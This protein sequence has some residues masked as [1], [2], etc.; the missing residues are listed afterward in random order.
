MDQAITQW[1]NSFAGIDPISDTLMVIITQS[2]V[3]A[4]VLMVATQCLIKSDRRHTRHVCLSAGLTFLISLGINQI[5]IFY[6]HR[7]R[8]YDAGVS[9]LIVAPSTDWA[10]PSDHST[11]AFSIAA[12]FIIH[13]MP[14][15]G[16]AFSLAATIV[17]L[18]R[19]YVGTHYVGD[20]LGGAA[21]AFI[22][23]VAVKHAFPEGNRLDRLATSIL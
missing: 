13:A 16:L 11:A 14:R 12:A 8:P 18:S 23:A 3:P 21:V 2:A 1:I 5:I 6:V 17:S 4:M 22:T 20:V 7:V 19:I 9:H 10:F 15:R